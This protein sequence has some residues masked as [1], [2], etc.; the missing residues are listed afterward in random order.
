MSDDSF[1]IECNR[2]SNVVDAVQYERLRWAKNEGPMLERLVELARAAI[3]DRTDFELTDEGSRGA[4]K[5][6]VLKVHSMR[7]VAIN[8]GLE[9]GKV[10]IWAEPIERSKYRIGNPGRYSAEFQAVDEAWMK[11]VLQAIIGQVQ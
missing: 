10:V 1:E 8:L 7:I 6:F 5:R 11:G 9:E 2:L 3:A 4:I